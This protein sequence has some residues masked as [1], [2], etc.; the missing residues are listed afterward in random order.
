[1]KYGQAEIIGHRGAAGLAPENSRAAFDAAI[2]HGLRWVETDIRR[3]ADGVLVIWHDAYING[4]RIRTTDFETLY[5]VSGQTLL[6]LD[7]LLDSFVGKIQFNFD[8]KDPDVLPNVIQEL[9]KRELHKNC[10]ISS[11]HHRAMIEG[12]SLNMDMRFAP[13]I[14]SRPASITS[15]LAWFAQMELIVTDSDFTDVEMVREIRSLG[16]EIY[17]YN[18]H[19]TEAVQPLLEAGVTGIIVDRPDIFGA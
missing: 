19:S 12:K 16:Y 11:F 4:H 13:I 6:H 14:A 7:N 15:F 3:S 9:R 10:L 2:K 18:V 5:E 8:I 1:M 17:L